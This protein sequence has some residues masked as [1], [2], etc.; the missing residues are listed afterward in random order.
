MTTDKARKRTVRARMAKTGE[1]Y[2][3]ARRNLVRP[4]PFATDDL[5]QSDEA[6]RRATGK[7][8][9]AWVRLLDDWGAA[10]RTHTEIARHVSSELGVDGWWA[11]SVTVGYER[12]R[13]RRAAN[14]RADGAFCAYVSKTVPVDALTLSQ[15]MTDARRRARWLEPGTLRVRTSTPGRSARFDLRGG[16][17]RVSAWFEAKG[18]A[19]STVSLQIEP[20]PDRA[21]LEA[22]RAEWRGHLAALSAS[23]APR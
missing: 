9:T 3:A 8:W 1:R 20:L 12:A 11:Q 22:T 7:G 15:A 2:S 5:G 4:A 17:A 19:R 18:P 14:Q 6:I 23:L 10:E 13:G 16:P 21:S